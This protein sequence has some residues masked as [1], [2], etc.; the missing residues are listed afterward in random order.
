MELLSKD[1]LIDE[2]L[3]RYPLVMGHFRRILDKRSQLLVEDKL[4]RVLSCITRDST[5]VT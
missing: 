3:G 1:A 5:T 4:E 2:L